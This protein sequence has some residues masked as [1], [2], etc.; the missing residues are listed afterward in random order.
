M[1]KE[2][3]VDGRP[4]ISSYT[5]RAYCMKDK[6]NDGQPSSRRDRHL[7]ICHRPP[8]QILKEYIA[9]TLERLCKCSILLILIPL[10]CPDS[11]GI[12]QTD[13]LSMFALRSS[14]VY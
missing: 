2:N 5:E 10:F 14:R 1:Y 12:L 8:K 11:G 13:E 9:R 4:Y 6:K 3:S 7:N